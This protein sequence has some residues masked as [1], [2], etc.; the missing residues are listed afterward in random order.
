MAKLMIAMTSA[1][2]KMIFAIPTALA[3]M[4]NPNTPAISAMMKKTN[5]HEKTGTS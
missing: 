3:A 4:N 2:R 5:A 1:T